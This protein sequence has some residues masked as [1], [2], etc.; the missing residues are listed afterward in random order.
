MLTWTLQFHFTSLFL[1]WTNGTFCSREAH[2]RT[3]RHSFLPQIRLMPLLMQS[4]TN[5]QFCQVELWQLTKEKNFSLNFTLYL[6]YKISVLTQ[7]KDFVMFQGITRCVYPFFSCLLL[8]LDKVSS[9]VLVYIFFNGL[10]LLLCV[11]QPGKGYPVR[12]FVVWMNL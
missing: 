7:G 9:K 10:I 12:A 8:S 11:T 4:S 1:E 3:K 2:F 5:L 6:I